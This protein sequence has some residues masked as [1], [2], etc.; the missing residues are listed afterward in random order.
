MANY[1]TNDENTIGDNSEPRPRVG[2][3]RM[4]DKSRNEVGDVCPMLGGIPRP[5]EQ[6]VT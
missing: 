5:V 3:Q 4:S 1:E 6:D 2:A